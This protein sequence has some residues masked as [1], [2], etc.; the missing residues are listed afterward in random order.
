MFGVAAPDVTSSSLSSSLLYSFVWSI[1]N[2]TIARLVMNLRR[3]SSEGDHKSIE[4][5]DDE[6]V[7][8]DVK[9][10]IE[11]TELP[12]LRKEGGT[13]VWCESQEPLYKDLGV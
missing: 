8:D 1:S 11:R 10:G 12:M 6:D 3:L 9:D 4:S 2:I 13:R 7:Q 5:I